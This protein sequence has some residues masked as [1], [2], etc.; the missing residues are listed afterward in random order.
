MVKNQKQSLPSGLRH[1]LFVLS[2]L[3][4]QPLSVLAQAPPNDMFSNAIPIGGSVASVTGSNVG[5][6]KE[7]GEPSPGM[8][9]G[10]KSIWWTWTAPATGTV[11]VDTIGSSVDTLLAVYRGSTLSSLSRQASDDDSG[12]NGAS[13]L[14]FSASTGVLYFIQAD[15]YNPSYGATNPIDAA[16]GNITVNLRQGPFPPAITNQPQ[17][18]AVVTGAN[19]TFSVKVTGG[20][21]LTF[22]WLKNTDPIPDAT[23]ISYSITG[24]Q[25][26]DSGLYSVVVSNA[27]GSVTSSNA[28]LTVGPVV[29]TAQPTNV[30]VGFGYPA[31]LTV[32]AAGIGPLS[33]QWQKGGVPIPS[34]TAS[35]YT[36][37]SAAPNDADSYAV[38]VSADSNS[39][40]SSNATLT[41]LAYTFGTLAGT[42]GKGGSADGKGTAARFGYPCGIALDRAGNL[43]VT[44]YYDGTVRKVTS[45]GTVTTLAGAY[46]TVGTNDGIGAE[47]LFN[48]PEGIAVDQ[49]TN[50]YVADNFNFTIRKIT[51]DNHGTNWIVSTLAGVPTVSGWRD[52]AGGS[53]LF[54]QPSCLGLDSLG[55]IFVAEYGN[56]TAR[57]ITPDG[58]VTT[59]AATKAA[60]SQPDGAAVD[61]AGNMF[62]TCQKNGAIAK[63]T[64]GGIIS[65]LARV[66]GFPSYSP[67]GGALDSAGNFYIA[68]DCG[69][70]MHS[71]RRVTPDGALTMLA[72][73]STRGF[74][75]GA[76][77]AARF[78]AGR[79]GIAVDALG[80]I[81]V[82]DTMNQVIRKGVPFAVTTL[83]QSQAAL[84]GTSV[85][86]STATA[87][88]GP[89]F[90]QWLFDGVPL[91][92]QTNATLSIG[93]LARTN[94]GIYSVTVS[95]AV[96]NWIT[97]DAT[98]RVL[99]PPVL[100]TPQMT[101]DGA[102]RLLFQ[103]EDGGTPY[104]L[105]HVILQWRTNLPSGTDTTW[106]TLASGFYL[107]NGIIA[108]DDTNCISGPSRF[109]RILEQ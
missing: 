42:P 70:G 15:G 73:T 88:N 71:V 58:F 2:A 87:G 55:N 102:I 78:Y 34:A 64:S 24:T 17:S 1:V 85:T 16:S 46:R 74:A 12:G 9:P 50:L 60:L 98:V 19:A 47:A 35:T 95:N 61:A 83:P 109:Y 101:A 90:F 6:T 79:S 100:Q 62:I 66:G 14:T 69:A 30:V 10:G 32:T 76:G 28:L 40:T 26:G 5:A 33:Y 38:V 3:G 99:L 37:A 57:K 75:D 29:I 43:Y 80:N 106:Q 56:Q 97:F 39:V 84:A 54:S 91:P 41:V 59:V 86:L 93:P 49:A 4:L 96:G 20:T 8:Y 107:T 53:A 68:G 48:Y 105:S 108:F 11:T 52:G 22:Q 94:S 65:I 23:N 77:S 82:A 72:G 36:I 104:D 27:Q 31:T 7:T 89:F 45:D 18:Q 81:Y 44:T 92:G 103:D 63:L 13:K 25:P 67:Y 51:P 21:P